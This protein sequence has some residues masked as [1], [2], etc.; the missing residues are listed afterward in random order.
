MILSFGDKDTEQ[1]FYNETS[2]RFAPIARI[3]LRKLIQLNRAV[4]LKD[5]AI[6]PGNHL[7]ALK[8]KSHGWHSIRINN[9]WRIVFQWLNDGKA[10]VSIVDYH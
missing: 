4:V 9:Q 10:N 2:R 6:P 1:L 7:E 3:A 8:R 5:L